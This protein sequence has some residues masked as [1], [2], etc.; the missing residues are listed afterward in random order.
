MLCYIRPLSVFILLAAPQ[1]SYALSAIDQAWQQVCRE[2]PVTQDALRQYQFAVVDE[3]AIITDITLGL[4]KING[5]IKRYLSGLTKDITQYRKN[6]YCALWGIDNYNIK[7]YGARNILSY[8]HNFRSLHTIQKAVDNQ[9][10]DTM[11]L[12]A[13][14]QALRNWLP[15]T[16]KQYY[17][18]ELK[19]EGGVIRYYKA[20]KVPE[21]VNV[22]PHQLIQV[23]TFNVTS[24]RCDSPGKVYES[25]ASNL[26]LCDI[27][28]IV[29]EI[30]ESLLQDIGYRQ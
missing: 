10:F 6:L 18:E 4:P 5:R 8:Y 22:A 24:R 16:N 27:K 25:D 1:I 26:H 9:L 17:L 19:Q 11:R 23:Q 14:R 20:L 15:T 28:I 29:P 30:Y 21:Y 13:Y 2:T 12:R 3:T 7:K